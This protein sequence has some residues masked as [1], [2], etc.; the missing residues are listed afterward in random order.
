MN[1]K[2]GWI[3]ALVST[4]LLVGSAYVMS[5]RAAAYNRSDTTPQLKTEPVAARSFTVYDR[6]VAITDMPGQS[7]SEFAVKLTYGDRIEIIPAKQPVILNLKGLDLYKEWLAVLVMKPMQRGREV[8]PAAPGPSL[9]GPAADQNGRVVVVVRATPPGYDPETWGSVRRADWTF[10]FYELQPDGNIGKS[11]L[12]WPRSDKSEQ[13]FQKH[14]VS[15]DATELERW[16]AQIPRL[17]DRSWQYQAAL[18]AMPT[19]QVPK[20][21]FKDDA[22]EVMGWTL[23]V[24]GF[25]VLGIC[26]GL[27]VAMAPRRR[28]APITP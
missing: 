2:S 20:Y 22:V 5:Q 12:R 25:S 14:A 16:L 4:I 26:A 3:L 8:A 1:A 21:K 11:I 7:V 6:E 15:A 24:A 9:I 19:L 13:R 27:C 18:F 17:E 10:R 28:A 23:P